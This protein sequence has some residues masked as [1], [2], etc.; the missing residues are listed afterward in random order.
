MA[1]TGLGLADIEMRLLFSHFDMDG[2]SSV[3]FEE[4]LQVTTTTLL[5]LLLYYY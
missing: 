5:L 2:N 4:F 1:E 3:D